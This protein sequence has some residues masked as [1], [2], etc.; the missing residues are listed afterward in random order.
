MCQVSNKSDGSEKVVM[1]IS[2]TEGGIDNWNKGMIHGSSVPLK[3]KDWTTYEA[4]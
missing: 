3:R 1:L 2:K 4:L